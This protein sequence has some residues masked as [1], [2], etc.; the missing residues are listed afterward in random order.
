MPKPYRNK[1]I[2]KHI[3]REMVCCITGAPNP[4]G[5][6]ILGYGFSGMGTK[7]PDYLQMAISHPLHVE[8]HQRGWKGFETKY[9]RTQ[10]S[11]VA[12]TL[13]KLHADGVVNL[14]QLE[15]DYG[16]PK[17]VWTEMENLENGE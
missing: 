14:R 2:A 8:I 16:L 17:W 11:M 10:K 6:H 5:H 12:E 3:Q 1:K 4:D 15:E 9:G 13:A 7:A